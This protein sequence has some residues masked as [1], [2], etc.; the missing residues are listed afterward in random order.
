MAHRHDR[1]RPALGRLRRRPRQRGQPQPPDRLRRLDAGA[2]QREPGA[3]IPT[4]SRRGTARRWPTTRPGVRSPRPLTARRGR[5]RCRYRTG[6]EIVRWTLDL[7]NDGAVDAADQADAERRGRA[8]HAQ[9]GRLRAGA[10]GLRRQHQQRRRATT[11]RS[12]QRVALVRRPGSGVPPMFTVYLRGSTH[13]VGLVERPGARGAARRHRAHR[14]PDHRPERQARLARPLRREPLQ[15]R[16]ELAAQHPAVQRR[17]V[18]RGR[19]RLPRQHPGQPRPR[20]RRA[21]TGRGDHPAAAVLSTVDRAPAATSASTSRRG[22]TGSSRSSRPPAT[23]TPAC[24][25]ASRSRCPPAT[26]RYFPDAALAGR[27]IISVFVFEDL[28]NDGVQDAGETG[29]QNVRVTLRPGGTV[30]LHGRLGQRRPPR[31]S[32]RWGPARS[33]VDAARLVRRDHDEPG[34]R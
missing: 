6:A 16:G 21:R 25:R 3:R 11:G 8:A 13:A 24:P 2:H 18:R 15:H 20:P 1:A 4:R 32:P 5:R 28:D 12:T 27:R 34:G 22:R 14:R 26:T 33:R 9:P 10:P 23:S 19:L 31:C 7:N 29:Q 17:R 30:G